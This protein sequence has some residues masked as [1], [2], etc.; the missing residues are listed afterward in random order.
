MSARVSSYRLEKEVAR[1]GM[2]IVYRGIH[3]VFDEVVA[4]KEIFPQFTGEPELRERF[5][6]EARLQRRLQHPNI[7]QVRDFLVENDSFY[8]VMEFVEGESLAGRLRNLGRPM[9]VTEALP[10][11]QQALAGLG[12]AHGQGIVHRDIKPANIMLTGE[13]VAKLTDFGI[14]RA[15]DSAKLTRS[16][17]VMGTV[18]Y[19]SPEQIQGAKLDCRTDVYSMGI[20]LYEMLVGR[21]PFERP[22]NT[23]SDWPVC[24]GHINH[25]PTRPGQFVPELPDYLERAILKALEKKPEIRFASCEEFT[26][27]LKPCPPGAIELAEAE[28]A[29]R[30]EAEKRRA[31]EKA[32]QER[33][34]QEKV[35]RERAERE[36][37]AHAEAEKR[38]AEG[39]ARQERLNQEKAERERS[40]EPRFSGQSKEAGLLTREKLEELSP[41]R[42]QIRVN[43]KDALKY[44]WIPAGAFT[45]GCSPGD[46]ECGSHEK[47]PHTVTISRGFWITQTPVT[48]GAYKQFA[49]ATGHQ[50][51]PEPAFNNGWG[52]DNLPIVNV[53]WDDA[54]AYCKWMVGRLLTEAEWEYAARA[55]STEARYG[56]LDEI[57]WYEHN[58]GN[59]THDVAQKSP[60]G[61]GLYDTLGNV[62][63]WVSDWYKEDYYRGGPGQDP[64]GPP[65]GQLRVLRGGAWNIGPRGI[66]VSGRSRNV[67]GVRYISYGFRC[68]WEAGSR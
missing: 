23:D 20:M 24:D 45:M 54:Q 3:A 46:D 47:P 33:L 38:R 44:V 50:M 19:M 2:G 30:E 31:E 15:L 59:R 58:S 16:G 32:G 35:E 39:K 56:P 57:A 40:E 62:W 17:V 13:G 51:P 26:A 18:A 28:R 43:P 53:N 34:V 25:A 42:A 10:I 60:N 6:R 22:L 68:A 55:G 64:K 41:T 4:I 65:G 21:R 11:F 5:L 1:G 61:F 48:T 63:E 8:I 36:R 27:A 37:R 49:R 14:A 52:K 67:P 12:F 66:R 29:A 9:T 7:V